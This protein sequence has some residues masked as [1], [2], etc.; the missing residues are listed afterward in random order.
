MG[1]VLKF[2]KKD[3]N[4][5]PLW[6]DNQTGKVYSN[7]PKVTNSEEFCERMVRVRKSLDK[8]NKLMAEVRKE[9]K[10]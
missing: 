3:T 7:S 1:K 5:K 10:K 6:V 8:I 2:Q 9:S 4:A